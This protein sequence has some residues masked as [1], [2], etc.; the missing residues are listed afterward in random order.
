MIEW[1]A[2]WLNANGA[3]DYEFMKNPYNLGDDTGA[4]FG[5]S[6]AAVAANFTILAAAEGT[7]GSIRVPSSFW[8]SSPVSRQ[9]HSGFQGGGSYTSN[10]GQG[11]EK[12]KK[13][14]TGVVMQCFGPDS[15]P[16]CKAVDTV[17]YLLRWRT[18]LNSF[19][20]TKPHLSKDMEDILP[21]EPPEPYLDLICGIAHEPSDQN[22]DLTYADRLQQRD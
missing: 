12:L 17:A 22:G 20:A 21:K 8:T 9:P 16:Y 15:S 2:V 5:G 3:T 13:A 18:D 11:P 7:G 19:L 14:K 10:V 4:S 6:D 1:A